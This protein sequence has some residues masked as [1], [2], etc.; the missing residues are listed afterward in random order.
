MAE[1]KSKHQMYQLLS[2]GRLGHTLPSWGSLS[3]FVMHKLFASDAD[4]AITNKRCWAVRSLLAHSSCL[5]NLTGLEAWEECKRLGDTN[6][7]LSPMLDD[8]QRICY[9]HLMRDPIATNFDVWNLHYTEDPKPARLLHSKD[10]CQ[11][12]WL[13]GLKAKAYIRLHMDDIGWE[14]LLALIEE[15]PDHCIEFTIMSS[16]LHAFGPTNT[17]FWEV[18]TLTGEYEK[19]AFRRPYE[20][21]L[22]AECEQRS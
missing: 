19:N 18:R 2:A 16:S 11:Q 9:A 21:R 7:N 14:T 6:F 8:T 20:R 10:G 5:F 17:I 13:S 12:K 1:I 4:P 22:D 3:D 15:Y